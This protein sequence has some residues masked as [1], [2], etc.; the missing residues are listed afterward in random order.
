[1]STLYLVSTPIGNKLDISLRAQN[2]LSS[3]DVIL[4]EDTKK[5][6]IF[7]KDLG[8][9]NKLLSYH[10]HSNVSKINYFLKL[11]KEGASLAIISDAGTPLISD[12]GYELV[13]KAIDEKIKVTSIPGPSAVISALISSGLS[14]SSF[15]FEGYAPKK[16]GQLETFLKNLQYEMKTIIL[17]E[18]PKRIERLVQMIVKILGPK[19]KVS[20]AKELTKKFERVITGE[21]KEIHEL[22]IKDETLKKGEMVVVI[23][24]SKEKQL[25]SVE[26]EK[27]LF[28]EI[29]KLNGT[30]AAS[31]IVSKISSKTSK[32]IYSIFSES[33][34][35]K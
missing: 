22:I 20:L 4:C 9:K 24:G 1:M 23:E 11:L 34:N 13:A 3:V 21:A 2:V 16:K 8:I 31:K 12:P 7:L 28:E 30:K 5:S 6:G 29:Q 10:D 19:R 25:I 27:V 33:K 14:T 26:H 32:E 15:V 35:D 17:F 18:S